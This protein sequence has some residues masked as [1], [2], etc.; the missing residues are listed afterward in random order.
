MVKRERV[1]RDERAEKKVEGH[2]GDHRINLWV[3]VAH[4]TTPPRTKHK[5]ISPKR[6]ITKTS[7]TFQIS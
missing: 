2:R 1:E 7:S 6:E 3:P 5:K 4:K